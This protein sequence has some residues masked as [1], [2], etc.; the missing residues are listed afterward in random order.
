MNYMFKDVS[1]LVSVNMT[2]DNNILIE[3]MKSTFENCINLNYLNI[4]FF[5]YKYSKNPFK[6]FLIFILK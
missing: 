5:K 4:N 2:S 3:Y 1:H 6:V